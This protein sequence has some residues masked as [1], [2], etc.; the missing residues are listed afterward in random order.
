MSDALDEARKL[1]STV[2]ASTFAFTGLPSPTKEDWRSI[3]DGSQII[4]ISWPD[5]PP[6]IAGLI[7]DEDGKRDYLTMTENWPDGA[8]ASDV[9]LFYLAKT[10]DDDAIVRRVMDLPDDSVLSALDS[11]RP[12]YSESDVRDMVQAALA[13]KATPF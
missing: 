10:D 7:W 6:T 13:L 4:L 12:I 1:G 5:E 8:R 11:G 2:P 3:P 9:F